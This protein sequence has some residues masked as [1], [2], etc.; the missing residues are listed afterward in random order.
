MNS[1]AVALFLSI[2]LAATLNACGAADAG[3]EEG[4]AVS[5]NPSPSSQDGESGESGALPKQS[6]V[7][8]ADQPAT[9]NSPAALRFASNGE[10]GESGERGEGY[11][12]GE[13]GEFGERGE[14]YESGEEGESGRRRR[15]S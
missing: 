14:G 6:S 3:G 10:R 8:K 11:E 7:L 9:V 4:G 5:P 12:S 2:G 13:E 15:R 1:K